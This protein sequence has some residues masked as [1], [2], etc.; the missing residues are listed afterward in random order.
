MA[1]YIEP[2]YEILTKI[3]KESF[4]LSCEL[5]A[6]TC[7]KSENK[8]TEGSA[9]KLIKNLIKNKHLAMVEH[10]PNIT[11]KFICD[12]AFSHEL[13]RH[14]LCSFAQESQRYCKYENNDM[15]FIIPYWM[16]E[17][18]DIEERN[19]FYDVCH[20][21]EQKYKEL[22][23]KGLQAQAARCVLP[24]AVKT[25]VVVTA[26]I[27]EWRHLLQLRTAKDAH[28]EMQR[29]MRPLLEELKEKLPVFFED[30]TY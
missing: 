7:Y 11:V 25:E 30:I 17:S 10:C 6:R 12:R 28:P 24:N 4:L 16:Y 8:I 20:L 26:N 23:E 27:R 18:R 29:V 5:A 22:R 13:V 9:E 19:M 15:E 2:K 14:R 1:K 3:D 21:T